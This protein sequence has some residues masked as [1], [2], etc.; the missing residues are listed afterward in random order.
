MKQSLIIFCNITFDLGSNLYSKN[1][2]TSTDEHGKVLE[3]NNRTLQP[4]TI[5]TTV[6]S[7]RETPAT[8]PPPPTLSASDRDSMEASAKP[9]GR[10]ALPKELTEVLSS[11]QTTPSSSTSFESNT[12]SP[13]GLN[14]DPR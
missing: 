10:V 6:L 8:P 7:L 5:K 13:V 3:E 11:M 4:P 2:Y 12:S 9:N 1:I 14:R